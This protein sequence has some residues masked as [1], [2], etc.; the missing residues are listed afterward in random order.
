MLKTYRRDTSL[1]KVLVQMINRHLIY[2]AL[3]FRL[4]Y[5]LFISSMILFI[6]VL[7][8][9]GDSKIKNCTP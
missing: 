6:S 8:H 4:Y 3:G 5:D 7:N 2:A 9:F 1:R